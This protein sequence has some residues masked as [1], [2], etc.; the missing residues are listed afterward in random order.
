MG[1]AAHSQDG[2]CD[3]FAMSPVLPALFLPVGQPRFP[4]GRGGSAGTTSPPGRAGRGGPA[5]K[6]A[7]QVRGL[8]G[9]AGAAPELPALAMPFQCR[10][11][12][13]YFGFADSLFWVCHL[14]LSGRGSPGRS[15]P[16][17]GGGSHKVLE[18]IYKDAEGTVKS[19]SHKSGWGFIQLAQHLAAP[20]LGPHTVA[21]DPGGGFTAR[22][23]SE[24][25][26]WVGFP[27][28]VEI[29]DSLHWLSV[30]QAANGV[31]ASYP[32]PPVE[33]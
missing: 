12:T 15:A 17:S 6:H 22:L 30:V 16:A 21:P 2:T 25:M 3:S 9:P 31:S 4:P 1:V 5:P 20:P 24:P 18:D 26:Q 28:L 27:R 14:R 19:F 13:P 33:W 32:V 8:S 7:P 10:E 11:G 29:R 23:P